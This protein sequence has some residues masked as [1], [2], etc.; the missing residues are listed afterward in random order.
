MS[1]ELRTPNVRARFSNDETKDE[2]GVI[3]E[4]IDNIGNMRSKYE[5]LKDSG[6]RAFAAF[7]CARRF[8]WY[9]LGWTYFEAYWTNS[10]FI[11]NSTNWATSWDKGLC[12]TIVLFP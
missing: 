1:S 9:E 6:F 7:R 5:L 4:C 2:P 11:L 8:V 12:G 3:R 10:E